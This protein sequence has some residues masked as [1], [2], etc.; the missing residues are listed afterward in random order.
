MPFSYID[1]YLNRLI[2]YLKEPANILLKSFFV[3]INGVL[4][5]A[6]MLENDNNYAAEKIARK[7]E[8][9]AE[10]RDKNRVEAQAQLDKI[11]DQHMLHSFL[12]V[13]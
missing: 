12:Q 11:R 13:Q 8:E 10:R 4:S 9:L 7:A 6:K 1:I 3:Q 2:F 5:F